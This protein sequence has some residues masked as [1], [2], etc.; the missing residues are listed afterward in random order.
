MINAAAHARKQAQEL[1][2]DNVRWSRQSWRELYSLVERDDVTHSNEL[3]ND[4][5]EQKFEIFDELIIQQMF[6]RILD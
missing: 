5:L 4:K 2:L 6:G 1:E 3:I